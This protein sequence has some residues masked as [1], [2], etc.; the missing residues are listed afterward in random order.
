MSRTENTDR[1]GVTGIVLA[2][3]R[4]QRMGGVDKGLVLLGSRPMVQRVI[5]RFA[6]QV[7]ELLI[8]ANRNAD[9]YAG[10]GH[11]VVPDAITDFAGPLAGLHRGMLE[12]TTELVCTVPCD[13]PFLP[14]D[15]VSRLRTP[16]MAG[17]DLAVAAADARQQPVFCLC[18]RSLLPQLEA[19]L[20]SGQR[21][22]DA[23]YGALRAATVVFEDAAA[24][25][26]INTPDELR[27]LDDRA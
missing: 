11:R 2:G 15:L 10:F 12:A 21:R 25:A 9:R 23:W 20:A 26:N 18:R 7:D 19:Y 24:F 6:P 16:V 4:G 27:T 14:A 8:V 3:G 1:P 22:F 5:E 17:A 13:S